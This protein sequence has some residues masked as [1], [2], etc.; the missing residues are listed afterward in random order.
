MIVQRILGLLY[1]AAGIAKAFPSVENV[2]EILQAA[3]IANQGTWYE[4][5]SVW[6][7]QNG[8]AVNVYVGL[9]LGLIRTC[10][11]SQS[12]QNQMGHLRPNVDDGWL[13]DF[14]TSIP[15]PGYPHGC[16]VYGRCH[17]PAT[18]A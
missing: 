7:A 8:E 13:C 1:L 6:L 3:A 9:A 14:I 12:A 18:S 10:T 11:A 16:P 5:L 2:P 4:G 17:L 15:T